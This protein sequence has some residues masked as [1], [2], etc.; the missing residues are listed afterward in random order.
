MKILKCLNHALTADQ[1]E[2]LLELVDN[3]NEDVEIVLLEDIDK[4]LFD[5]IK[6]SPDN[7]QDLN[8]LAEELYGVVHEYDFV[9]LPI[10]SPAFM[11]RFARIL[12][13]YGTTCTFLFSHSERESVEVETNGVVEKK[14]VFK[15]KK[16]LVYETISRSEL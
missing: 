10:G 9:I 14:S 7:I 11:F 16:W 5:K 1:V 13:M 2:S 8:I 3:V 4:N 6:N 15:H 12:G